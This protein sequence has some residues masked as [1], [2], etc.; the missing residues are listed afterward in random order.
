MQAI[1]YIIESKSFDYRMEA[2][3][4]SE[5]FRKQTAKPAHQEVY[6]VSSCYENDV[7]PPQKKI[8]WHWKTNHLKMYLPLTYGPIW[9]CSIAILDFSMFF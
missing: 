6:N 2:S 7:D 9:W 3:N 8:T 4:N 5:F 1:L